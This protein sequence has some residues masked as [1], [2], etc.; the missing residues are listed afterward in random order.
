[1]GRARYNVV[2]GENGQFGD[3]FVDN[4]HDAVRGDIVVFATANFS[5]LNHASLERGKTGCFFDE[6]SWLGWRSTYRPVA[7]GVFVGIV[8]EGQVSEK[9]VENLV[10]FEVFHFEDAFGGVVFE[11]SGKSVGMSRITCFLIAKN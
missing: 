6:R 1:M 5:G 7:D 3:D 9:G 2:R 10:V 11:E 8:T 4:V